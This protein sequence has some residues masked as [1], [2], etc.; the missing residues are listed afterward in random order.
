MTP[1]L[2]LP[3]YE[4]FIYSLQQRYPLVRRSTLV[5]VRLGPVTVIIR[6]EIELPQGIRLVYVN[7]LLLSRGQGKLLTMG[8]RSGREQNNYIGMIHNLTPI[9]RI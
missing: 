6:G 5:V 4:R 7:K 8:M 9:T 3:D 2:S 1:F